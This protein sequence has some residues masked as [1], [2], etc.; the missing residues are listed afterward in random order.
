M[1]YMPKSV[2]LPNKHLVHKSGARDCSANIT[3]VCCYD[4]DS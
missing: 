1:L 4:G 3:H 2:P